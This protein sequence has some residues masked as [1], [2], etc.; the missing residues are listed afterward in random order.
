MPIVRNEPLNQNNR[1]AI[2][3]NDPITMPDPR[4]EKL[5]R[6]LNKLDTGRRYLITLTNTGE[7]DFTVVDLGKIEK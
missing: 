6:R 5:I 7:I 3:A 4:F 1:S 2:M